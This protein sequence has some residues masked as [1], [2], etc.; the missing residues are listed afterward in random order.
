MGI[1][2]GVHAQC[3]QKQKEFDLKKELL[4]VVVFIAN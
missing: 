1:L 4:N 3:G 2:M